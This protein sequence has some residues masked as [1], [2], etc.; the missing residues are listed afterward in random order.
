MPSS[1][2]VIKAKNVKLLKGRPNSAALTSENREDRQSGSRSSQSG[3]KSLG[4]EQEK[5]VKIIDTV[6]KEAYEKGFAEGEKL[7]KKELLD[8]VVAMSAAV[9]EIGTL[10]KKFY[11][12]NEKD[13]LQLALAV[14]RKVIHT[15]VSASS[16]VVLSVL[17]DAVKEIANEKGLKVR[18]NPD[19]LRVIMELKNDLFQENAAFKNA[20]FEGDAGIKRGGVALETEHLEVDARLEKQLDK[21][22]ESFKI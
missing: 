12:E 7:R 19:D 15:E 2:T 16:D 18:L 17:K 5:W 22:K 21:I 9:K 14:A 3:L 4:P 8:A 13:V 6:K 11:E 20:V 1:D 10:K